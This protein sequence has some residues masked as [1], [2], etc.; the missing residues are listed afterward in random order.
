MSRTTARTP[1]TLLALLAALALAAASGAIHACSTDAQAL[2]A[3]DELRDESSTLYRETA[4][5]ER[6]LEDALARRA[7]A[8]GWDETQTESFRRGL[9][10]DP[11][12]LSLRRSREDGAGL[13]ADALARLVTAAASERPAAI[14]AELS[15]A[16]FANQRLRTLLDLEYAWLNRKIWGP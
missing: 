5:V 4:A 16:R 12:Y 9:L 7:R 6:N 14:C 13:A 2:A 11:E 3:L 8:A 15:K 1:S 10:E